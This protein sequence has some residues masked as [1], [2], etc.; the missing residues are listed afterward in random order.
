M[1]RSHNHQLALHVALET[2][3]SSVPGSRKR[4]FVSRTKHWED[5][6]AKGEIAIHAKRV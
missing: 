5:T 3:P 6:N 2:G 1:Q 4:P